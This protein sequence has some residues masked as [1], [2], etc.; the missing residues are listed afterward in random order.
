MY[1]N[2]L[3]IPPCAHEMGAVSGVQGPQ[4]HAGIQGQSPW[5]GFQ[6]AEPLAPSPVPNHTIP[7][8]RQSCFAAG[9]QTPGAFQRGESLRTDPCPAGKTALRRLFLL[10]EGSGAQSGL[11]DNLPILPD[12]LG[13]SRSPVSPVWHLIRRLPSGRASGAHLCRFTLYPEKVGTLWNSSFS[14]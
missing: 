7:Y 1:R 11:T 2:S 10:I 6:R 13:G 12:R 5:P 4:A 3:P 8:R 14:R 9:F